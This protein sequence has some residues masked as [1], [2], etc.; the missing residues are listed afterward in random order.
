MNFFPLAR[1]FNITVQRVFGLPCF[2]HD[3]VFSI[4]TL[5]QHVMKAIKKILKILPRA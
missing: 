1:Y 3:G 2:S 5:S 4:S